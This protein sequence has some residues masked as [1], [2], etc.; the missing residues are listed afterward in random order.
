VVDTYPANDVQAGRQTEQKHIDQRG[1]VENLD[2]K[3]N[4]VAK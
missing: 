2:N 4:E 1:G 3:R